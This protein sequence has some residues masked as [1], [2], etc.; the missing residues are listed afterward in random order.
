MKT[1]MSF[2]CVAIGVLLQPLAFGEPVLLR[3]LDLREGGSS[4]PETEFEVQ[5]ILQHEFKVPPLDPLRLGEGVFWTA[6]ASGAVDFNPANDS[7][8]LPFARRLSDGQDDL[9]FLLLLSPDGG[10]G[11]GGGFESLWLGISPDLQGYELDSIRLIV[12]DVSIEPWEKWGLSGVTKTADVT[13]EFWGHV[14]PEPTSVL[15]VTIGGLIL[16]NRRR[17]PRC[18]RESG[19]ENRVS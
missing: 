5:I 18:T 11:G 10:G 14:I 4:A 7:S 13:Y 8:F 2:C 16:S 9:L 12:H 15:F 3:S 17:E 19:R 6:G 1:R